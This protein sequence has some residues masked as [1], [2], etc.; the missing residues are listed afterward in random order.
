VTAPTSSR[1]QRSSPDRVATIETVLAGRLL[2]KG[3]L[4]AGE[5]GLGSDGTILRIGRDVRGDRRIEFGDRVLLPSA[6]DLHV[7][8][9]EPGASRTVEN[10]ESGTAQAALGGVGLV[11][12][13]PNTVP[14]VTS[15]ETLREKA[16]LARGRLHI[17]ALLYASANDV[18]TIPALG[19]EAGAFKLY[20]APTTGLESAPEP[21]V[22]PQILSAVAATGLPL[23][24]HAEDPREFRDVPTKDTRGWNRARPPAA[25]AAGIALL[26]PA[27]AD[28]RLHVAHVTRA[29]TA[30]EL[31][32][33]GHSF[34]V[35]P[36]HLL[37]DDQFGADP[38]GKVNPP[39]R[40]SA[41]R[42]ALWDRFVH[43]G[44][45]CLA[46]DHAPHAIRDK[47]R[48][49]PIAPSGMP[50]VETMLPLLLARVREAELSL[51]T[52]VAATADRPAR[53]FGLPQGR[54]AVGHRGNLIV[55]DFR[56]RVTVA[57]ERLHAPCGWTA[58][59]GHTAIFPTDHFLD[60][61]RIV[62]DGALVG[63]R[64]GRI[65]RPEFAPDAG[66]LTANGKA[67]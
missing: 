50:N 21:G 66:R 42:A 61:V 65:R 55:V 34:E 4:T 2:W 11:G 53:W 39:L 33:L 15:V 36:Q 40:D 6:V 23:S 43:G 28:L 3:K 19:R 7:H 13:M 26:S 17:D 62:E 64:L 14:P 51:P 31:T 45:P 30:A 1:R 56:R 49:F 24:V 60:G 47:E 18:A 67:V 27:P 8:L 58:F 38:R 5:V 32:R 54:L 10:L 52:L 41:D 48:A 35:T 59:E 29:E 46:S 20:L 37:L 44:I 9:R 57:A 63:T 16:S 12:E 22:V 25:E